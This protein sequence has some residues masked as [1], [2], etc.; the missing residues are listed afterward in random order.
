[1]L[2]LPA[3]R[4]RVLTPDVG[5]GFGVKGPLYPEDVLVSVAAMQVERPVKWIED[6]LEHARATFQDRE[7]VHRVEV[8]VRSDGTLVSLIDR[9]VYDTGAFIPYGLLVGVVAL[10]TIPGPYRIPNM[11][12]E[13]RGALT[14]KVPVG[15][16]RG[17]GRPQGVYV[18]ERVMDE[19]ARRLELDPLE[20]RERNFIQPEEFPY[21][22]GLVSQ[23]N[24]PQEYD[25]GN[26]PEAMR[27]IRDMIDLDS[28]RA[29]QA[30]ARRQGRLLGL[31]VAFYVEGCGVGPYEGASV[32]VDGDGVVTLATGA[33]SQGQGHLTMFSQ[34]V[35]QEL[36]VA[37]EQ[38]QVIG[39][40][41]AAIEHGIGTY[42][43][44]VAVTA[45]N[46]AVKAARRVREHALHLAA[47][48]FKEPVEALEYAG[49]QVFIRAMP[50]RCLSLARLAQMASPGRGRL[51]IPGI[52]ALS[53]TEYF[54]PGAAAS[55]SGVHA[56][57]IEID[58]AVC[59]PR[60][61]RYMVVHDCGVVINPLIVDGQVRGGVAQGIGGSL[62]EKLVYDEQGQLLTGSLMDYLIPTA[63]EIPPMEVAHIESPSPFN[64]LGVKGAGE[65]GTL[66]AYAAIARAIEDA[67]SPYGVVI[68]SMPVLPADLHALITGAA[69]TG[70]S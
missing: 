19:V 63:M 28:F 52:P 67:L 60:I 36:G 21:P 31:G 69:Q 4:V 32:R 34:L 47:E 65:G 50:Q 20:V 45:G 10:S 40:D 7:Q 39:G 8:G 17:A 11:L 24:L 5:G 49:G 66:S 48:F 41:T 14:H 16:Y 12:L 68:R 29:E 70:E 37:P 55:S 25:S 27:L 30:E 64:P 57:V 51:P 3:H 53:A 46:A 22:T 26:F 23:D 35:A 54:E 18:I 6:R 42:A 61:R 33:P 62:Y 1:M 56:C 13:L 44:R 2:A 58:P 38:I 9:F 59:M 43:S 15:A